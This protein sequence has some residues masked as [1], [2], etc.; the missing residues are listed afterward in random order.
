MREKCE[1]LTWNQNAEI[2]KNQYDCHRY[3]TILMQ[4][5]MILYLSEGK[6]EISSERFKYINYNYVAVECLDNISIN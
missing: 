2:D 6:F 3:S 1:F 4:F 5:E